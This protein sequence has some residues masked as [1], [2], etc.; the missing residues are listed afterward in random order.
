MTSNWVLALVVCSEALGLKFIK[1]DKYFVAKKK[2]GQQNYLKTTT[3]CY[4]VEKE[5]MS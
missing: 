1:F 2:R 3:M 5:R 4:I